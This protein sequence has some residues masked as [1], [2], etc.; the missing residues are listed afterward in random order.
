MIFRHLQGHIRIKKA[1]SGPQGPSNSAWNRLDQNYYGK[2]TTSVFY[3]ETPRL[4]NDLPRKIRED[5]EYNLVKPEEVNAVTEFHIQYFAKLAYGYRPYLDALSKTA[6]L[7][8][9]VWD[10]SKKAVL[11][12][13]TTTILG[14]IA[15]RTGSEAGTALLLL[16]DTVDMASEIGSVALDVSARRHSY[17]DHEIRS[18]FSK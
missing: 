9:A 12:A 8:L 2:K 1:D 7:A 5:L 3:K 4:Y 6:G 10:G 18:I 16:Y 15:S 13:A 17:P 14:E 11:E